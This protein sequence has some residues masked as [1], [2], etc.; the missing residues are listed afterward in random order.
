MHSDRRYSFGRGICVQG[1]HMIDALVQALAAVVVFLLDALFVVVEWWWIGIKALIS[2][3][4]E[5]ITF[6][7]REFAEA[8]L[9]CLG[10]EVNQADAIGAQIGALAGDA[11]GVFPEL[12]TVWAMF[13]NG[14]LCVIGWY[15]VRWALKFFPLTD[16]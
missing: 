15:G 2:W 9:F 12:V 1:H 11:V 7:A 4:F 6:L 14:F 8:A 13:Q 5:G 3:L 16:G 10:V